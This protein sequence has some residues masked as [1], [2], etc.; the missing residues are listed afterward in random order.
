ME[1]IYDAEHFFDGYKANPAYALKTL[2]AALEGGASR[3]VLCDTNGG[4][5]PSELVAIVDEV[6]REFPEVPLGIHAHNDSGVAVANSIL[7]VEHGVTHVQGTFNGY[8]ERCGNANLCAIIPNLE[9]KMG[10]QCL[11]PGALT[12]LTT[13]SRLVAELANQAPDE[14]QPYVGRSAFAHKGGRAH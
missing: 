3:L 12:R 13:L 6:H 10:Y 9:L 1:V 14:R 8:G 11:L 5:L 7:A 4:T 2:Q